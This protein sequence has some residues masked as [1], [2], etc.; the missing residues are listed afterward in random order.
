M[1]PHR[2]FQIIHA[3]LGIVIAA[4]VIN[5]GHGADEYFA[6][7]EGRDNA[8]AHLP[9]EAQRGDHRFDGSAHPTSEAPAEFFACFLLA[10]SLKALKR[11][12]LSWRPNKGGG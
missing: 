11:A 5:D 8:D 6:R 1:F 2:H 3:R 12:N 4:D 10:E 7:R 9:I